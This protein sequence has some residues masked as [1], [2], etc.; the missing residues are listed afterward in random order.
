M[1]SKSLTKEQTYFDKMYVKD[2]QIIWT[3]DF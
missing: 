2:A 3:S 1:V